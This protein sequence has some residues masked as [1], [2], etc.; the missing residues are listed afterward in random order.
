MQLTFDTTKYLETNLGL[1]DYMI[2]VMYSDGGNYTAHQIAK[3]L[4]ITIRTA[5][6]KRHSLVSLG[7]LTQVGV[8]HYISNK[9]RQLIAA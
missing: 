5:Y 3:H 2:L 6:A 7:W 4:G 9:T 8:N 1:Y